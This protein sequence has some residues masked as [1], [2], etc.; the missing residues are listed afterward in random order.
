MSQQAWGAL[1]GLVGAIGVLLVAAWIHAC[2]PLR[3][4]PRIGPFVPALTGV[5]NDSAWS[6]LTTSVWATAWLLV[7]PRTAMGRRAS[8][9]GTAMGQ[10]TT[11]IQQLTWAVLGAATGCVVGFAVSRDSPSALGILIL[12][13]TGGVSGYLAYDRNVAL[14]GGRR[15]TRIDQQLPTVA[16]LLA[17]AV[18]AG[19]SPVSAL[20][21]VARTITGE[22]GEEI[23]E[24][25]THVRAGTSVD[26]ALSAMSDRVGSVA[27]SR[28]VDGLLVALSRGTPLADVLRAQAADCRADERRRLV[29]VAGR[30]DVMMLVP[31]VFLILPTVVLV[32]LFPGIQS[33]R[34]VVA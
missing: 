21:R 25:V 31:V 15:R 18:A 9:G 32:A 28:F 3:I 24:C 5:G 8:R 33:L 7:R 26:V 20:D 2:R 13:L 23:A 11:P 10:T 22:L 6:P 17:F 4:G 29:E 14:R 34:L 27:L 16:E 19:E 12:G 1:T 30:K